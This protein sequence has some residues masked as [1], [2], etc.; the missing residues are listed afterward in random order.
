MHGTEFIQDLAV[1]MIVAGATTVLM[2]WLKQP[3]VLGYII[4]GMIIG[5]HTP[6]YPLITDTGTIATFAELDAQIAAIA[7]IRDMAVATRNTRDFENCGIDLINPWE[8]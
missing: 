8:A 4:A 1:L 2:H 6:P 3:V 5:P 7:R